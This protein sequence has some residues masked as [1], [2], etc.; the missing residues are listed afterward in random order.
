MRKRRQWVQDCLSQLNSMRDTE[1]LLHSTISTLGITQT[2]LALLSL[3]EIVVLSAIR[4]IENKKKDACIAPNYA[5]WTEITCEVV[6][7]NVEAVKGALNELC[8]RKKVK[9]GSTI[10]DKYFQTI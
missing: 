2:S 10:N 1:I 6:G 8:R 7:M 4:K 9:H 3:N 5:L